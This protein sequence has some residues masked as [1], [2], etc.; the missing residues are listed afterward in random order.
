MSNPGKKFMSM[1]MGLVDG[2][3]YIEAGPQKQYNKLTKLPA[4]ST[5]R[6]RLVLRMHIR[7]K[8]LLT[9]LTKVLG[10]GS[11]SSLDSVNQT[12]LR[13]PPRGEARR[14]R[15][16][17]PKRDL[18]TVIIALIKLYNLQF[19]TINRARQYAL[20]NYILENNIV[21]WENIEFT[22]SVTEYSVNDKFNLD[23][24]AGWLVGF[25]VAEGSFG[26]KRSG[27]A[28]YQIKQKGIE[29]YAVSSL[30]FFF[31]IYYKKKKREGIIKAICLLI[32]G[33]E[34]L[35]IKADAVNC[36]QLTLSSKNDVQKVVDFFSSPDNSLY[37]Y[38]LE[39][40]NLWL[41]ALKGAIGIKIL[42]ILTKLTLMNKTKINF[43]NI[44]MSINCLK[45]WVIS[46]LIISFSVW[47][48]INCC[49]S[50]ETSLFLIM[51]LYSTFSNKIKGYKRIG[52]HSRDIIS[53]IFGSLLGEGDV[54]RKKDGTR[55]TFFQEAMHVK[56]LLWLHNQL[57][58]AGYCNPTEPTIGKRLGKKGKVRKIIR[59]AT[60]TYTSFD[61]IYDLWYKEGVKVVPQCMGDYLTPLALAI[62][63][64]ESGV[65]ASG[66]LN[67]INCFSY[68]DC[69]LLVQ[70]LHKNFGLKAR[71][72][73]TGVSSQYRVYLPKESMADLRNKV[74]IFIIP[75]MKYKLL[76]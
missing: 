14:G 54:E 64:M 9:Y 51:P 74:G 40:Y 59:F 33:R 55:I 18:V 45:C 17:F 53:I 29:N 2:D 73:S 71:I 26:I 57:A 49:Q 39:Q 48:F 34:A 60:W 22:P 61:W 8:S 13:G 70:V 42:R 56:Y 21:H 52:P 41:D 69:L 66:G 76:P 28:F 23:F 67:F 30:F 62:W 43:Y 6:A 63:V 20:L 24:F 58:T 4:K 37:G 7:D 36:Y 65:K 12:P 46:F 75:S 44:I 47:Q 16:I 3:G 38:K 32:A 10:V 5:I 25:T 35:P 31:S 1:F 72:Q 11:L 50:I 68:S 27:E 15:L 19:L